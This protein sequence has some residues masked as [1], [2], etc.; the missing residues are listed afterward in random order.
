MLIHISQSPVEPKKRTQI[1]NTGAIVKL[2]LSLKGHLQCLIL[3]NYSQQV[4]NITNH[5]HSQI[6]IFF[7]DI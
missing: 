4:A 3:T 5:T 1:S 7:N 2:N 6:N